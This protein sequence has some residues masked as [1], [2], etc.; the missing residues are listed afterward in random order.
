MKSKT[1]KSRL[2]SNYILFI[3]MMLA[4]GLFSFGASSSYQAQVDDMFKRNIM[5]KDVSIKLDLLDDELLKYLSTKNS[6][7]LNQYMKH[8]EEVQVMTSDLNKTI[9]HYSE[10]DLMILDITAMVNDLIRHGDQAVDFKRKSDVSS[11]NDAY[12]EVSLVKGYISNYIQELNLRQLGNNASQYSFMKSQVSKA[13]FY[14][15]FLIIDLLMLSF[16]VIYRTTQNITNPIGYLSQSA[17][18]M[19][20]GQYHMEDVHVK[21]LDEL[22]ILAEAFNRMKKSVQSHFDDLKE[23]AE[24]EAKLKDQELENLKMQNLLEQSRMYAL[25]SQMN[26]HFLF[27]TVNAAVQLS[28]MEE[29][30]RTMMFLESMARLF[31]YNVKELNTRVSLKDE[32]NNIRDYLELL[33]VRF[34]DMI[35]YDFEVDEACLD[36]SMPPLILQPIVENAYMHGL[37]KK[38]DKGHLTVKVIYDIVDVKIIISDDGVGMS[39]NTQ[40]TGIG[41]KNLDK[42]LD[43]FYSDH[44]LIIDS[45]LGQG[46]QVTLILPYGDDHV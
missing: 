21:G 8:A 7:H 24:T 37:S 1:I 46:T 30:P 41:L 28:K 16:L 4:I 32:I 26:P 15:V 43:L 25:Q 42:R 39:K 6:D 14:H 19:S 22:E 10:E 45:D 13:N 11:Y 33:S 27:N 23:K 2:F 3:I 18:A 36:L 9:V 29:S 34:G 44:Q 17:D 31:R 20:K 35:E 12:S 40:S 38:E 5:L